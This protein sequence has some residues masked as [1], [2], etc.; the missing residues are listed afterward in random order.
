MVDQVKKSKG[1][2][3][4]D[5]AVKMPGLIA[6]DAYDDLTGAVQQVRLMRFSMLNQEQECNAWMC[7]W[8]W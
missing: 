8:N 4:K 7:R 2:N 6:G 1:G 3:L 5:R